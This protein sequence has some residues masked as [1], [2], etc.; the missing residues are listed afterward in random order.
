MDLLAYRMRP[1]NSPPG[2]ERLA[3][4]ALQ[5][6][7][8]KIRHFNMSTYADEVRLIFDIFND[9]WS[10]N[11]GF[12][13]F[14]KAE[15]DAMITQTRPIMR[16]KFGRIVEIDGVPSAM[17]VAL[18][19][20]NRVLAPFKGRLLPLNWAKLVYAIWS[21]RWKTARIPLLGLRKTLRR[22]PL[23]LAVLSLLVSEFLQLGRDYDLDWV[24]FSWILE[25]NEPMVKLAELAAGSPSKVFRIYEAAL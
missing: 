5:S 19:D 7:R 22:T 20:L 25:T 16:S 15:I 14:S 21:D 8:V 18:P 12:V 13:A 2:L 4:L 24:E 9:G 10:D 11:W 1:T 6:G 23:A 17:M 3:R